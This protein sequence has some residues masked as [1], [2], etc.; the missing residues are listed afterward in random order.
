MERNQLKN[1]AVFVVAVVAIMATWAMGGVDADSHGAP[2]SSC[3][4]MGA[5]HAVFP[6]QPVETCPF[7]ITFDQANYL[8]IY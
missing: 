8:Y 3:Q 7:G 1:G 4:D 5:I 2:L 6:A